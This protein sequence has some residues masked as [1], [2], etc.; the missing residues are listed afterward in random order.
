MGGVWRVAGD[1][2]VHWVSR[3]FFF[4]SS[5]VTNFPEIVRI[6]TIISSRAATI[7][8]YFYI[9]QIKKRWRKK[10]LREGVFQ[11][12]LGPQRSRWKRAAIRE[13]WEWSRRI[14]TV[15]GRVYLTRRGRW[16]RPPLQWRQAEHTTMPPRRSHKYWMTKTKFWKNRKMNWITS[17]KN[18]KQQNHLHVHLHPGCHCRSRCQDRHPR[19]RP[20]GPLH[21][22]RPTEQCITPLGRRGQAVNA[23]KNI[24]PED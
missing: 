22:S 14:S 15:N 10:S 20:M 12:I 8:Y 24:P 9:C 2:W 11:T 3:S 23:I 5:P 6:W 17:Y 16:P 19:L 4:S 18:W 13:R 7:F 21:H 1:I